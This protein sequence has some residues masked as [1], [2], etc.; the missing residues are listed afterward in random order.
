MF[1]IG[2]M[3]GLGEFGFHGVFIIPPPPSL[4]DTSPK[5]QTRHCEGR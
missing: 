4:R 1:E 2:F 5:I 3:S